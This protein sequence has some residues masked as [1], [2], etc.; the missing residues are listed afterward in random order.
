MDTPSF[1]TPDFGGGPIEYIR[2]VRAE[3]TKVQWPTREQVVRST[4]LVFAVSVVIGS[5]IGGI[6]YLFTSIFQMFIN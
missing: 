1:T 3:L 4:V 5:F 2:N 6:D